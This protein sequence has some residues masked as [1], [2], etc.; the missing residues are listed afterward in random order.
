[1]RGGGGVGWGGV[2]E[3]RWERGGGR[4]REGRTENKRGSGW[5]CLPG[6]G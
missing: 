5:S 6:A 3:D 4:G 2:G 1:V